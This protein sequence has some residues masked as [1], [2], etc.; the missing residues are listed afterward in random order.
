MIRINLLGHRNRR[1]SARAALAA[2]VME[3]GDVGSPKLKVS[4]GAGAGRRDLTSLT[5]TGWTTEKQHIA[6]KMAVGG[7]EKPR[8]GGREGPIP[9]TAAPGRQLQAAGRCDRPV[10]GRQTGPVNLLNTIGDTV[11]GTE[12]VWLNT[13]KD[14]GASVD[15]EGMALSTDAVATLIRICKRRDTSRTLKSKRR[16]RTRRSRKCRRFSS[17]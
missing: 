1:T 12:A 5:G 2:A 4:A 13:M 14:Q 6:A 10:A 17:F 11:N 8:T 3:M 9:G 15:I 16:I 7:A